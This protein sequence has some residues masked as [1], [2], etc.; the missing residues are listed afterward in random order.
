MAKVA[1]NRV[2]PPEKLHK[3]KA[4]VSIAEEAAV[5]NSR[6]PPPTI[7]W[8]STI[9]TPTTSSLTLNR[10]QSWAGAKQCIRSKVRQISLWI[11]NWFVISTIV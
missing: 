8:M 10:C 3:N 5:T 2:V 6:M 4:W 9:Q 7:R 1:R 11:F